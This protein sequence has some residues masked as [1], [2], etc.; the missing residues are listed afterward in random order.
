MFRIK[1][2][3]TTNY[4]TRIFINENINYSIL[5]PIQNHYQYICMRLCFHD[6]A[7]NRTCEKYSTTPLILFYRIDMPGVNRTIMTDATVNNDVVSNL[8]EHPIVKDIQKNEI[9]FISKER[10]N[11]LEQ[12]KESIPTLI[13]KAIADYKKAKLKMLHEKDKQNPAAV[14]AR[15]KK[16]NEKNRDKINAKRIMKRNQLNANSVIIPL[17]NVN[18]KEGSPSEDT[19]TVRF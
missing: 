7:G 14:N 11:S 15:V 6:V 9:T 5:L 1:N 16:Y 8:L 13:E 19:F 10:L 3:E 2:T 12:L 4:Q 17:E 18:V